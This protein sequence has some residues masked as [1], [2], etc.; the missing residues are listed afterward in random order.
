MIILKDNK[1]IVMNKVTKEIISEH[2]YTSDYEQKKAKEAAI[3][4]NEQW[5]SS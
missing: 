1:Y 5:K 4:S 2:P 3:A